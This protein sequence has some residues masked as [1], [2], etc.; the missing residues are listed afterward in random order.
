MEIKSMS[1]REAKKVL[2]KG[3]AILLDVRTKEEYEEVHIKNSKLIPLRE[4]EDMLETE[5]PDKEKI[6]L[7]YC[8]SG[9]RSHVAAEILNDFGYKDVYNIGGIQSW[10]FEVIK[11]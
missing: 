8:R 9:H 6:I 3:E 5:L 4:L 1:Q 11:K 10:P 7:V 2:D